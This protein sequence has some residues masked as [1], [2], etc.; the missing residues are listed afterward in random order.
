MRAHNVVHQ[1]TERTN[2]Q[3]S[4]LN[5]AVILEIVPLRWPLQT[6]A[7]KL[8]DVRCLPQSVHIIKIC[9]DSFWLQIYKHFA[10]NHTFLGYEV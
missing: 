7:E 9:C 1:Q 10:K 5:K 4:K 2:I 6:W 8:T 3:H